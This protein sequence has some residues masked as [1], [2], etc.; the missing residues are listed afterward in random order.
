MTTSIGT[1]RLHEG[2]LDCQNLCDIC[3]TSRTTRK[4]TACAKLRQALYAAPVPQRT[5]A[6]LLQRQGYRIQNTSA[7]SICLS[8]GNDYI[9]IDAAGQ[10]HRALGA[11]K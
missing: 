4:H 10:K 2:G 7:G 9:R 6:Q 3:G 8:R 1:G 5:A 11:R